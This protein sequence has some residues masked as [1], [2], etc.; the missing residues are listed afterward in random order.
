MKYDLKEASKKH[1]DQ[2]IEY[3]HHSIFDYATNLS[4]EEVTRIKEY[5]KNNIYKELKH[6]K[7]ITVDENEIGCVLV[8][9]KENKCFL[10][11]LYIEEKYRGKGIGTCILKDITNKYSP[12]YLWVYRQNTNAI[13]LYQKLGFKIIEETENRYL[14]ECKNEKTKVT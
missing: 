5:V 6:Y 10:D 2:L 14:M 3:K 11:E 4:I 8:T 7:M 1:I 12:I 9:E 13:A